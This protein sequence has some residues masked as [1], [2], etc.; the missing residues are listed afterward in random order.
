MRVWVIGRVAAGISLTVVVLLA[1]CSYGTTQPATNVTAT[2]AT[3]HGFVSSDNADGSTYWFEYGKTDLLGN[4]TPDRTTTAGDEPPYPAQEAISGLDPN[5]VYHFRL[6]ARDNEGQDT[7]ACK[8]PRQFRTKPPASTLS[9][10]T[11]HDLYPDYDRQITDYTVRCDEDPTSFAVTAPDGTEVSIDGDPARGGTFTKSVDLSTGQRADFSVTTGSITTTHHVRCLPLDFPAWD[12][13]LTGQ[14]TQEWTLTSVV[15]G[16]SDSRYVIFFNADGVPVWWYKPS[17]GAKPF[18]AKLLSDGNVGFGEWTSGS[19]TADPT[20]KFQVRRLDGS[21]ARTLRTVGTPTDFHEM[22]ELP[23]GHVLLM[24]YPPRDHV[25]LSAF[26]KPSDATVVDGEIQELDANGA[27]VWS[28][29]TKDHIALA[30][31]GR[32]WN[33]NGT[34]A[35]PDGRNAYDIVHMNA[36]EPDGDGLLVSLRHTDAIYRISRADGHV[37][38]KL[39]GTP[40]PQRLSVSHDSYSMTFGGQHD[41]RRLADG[42]VSVHDNGTQLNRPPR[43]V[44]FKINPAKKSA[45]RVETQADSDI[46]NSVCCG[47]ARKLDSN[48]WLVTWGGNGVI[49][50]YAAD[51]SRIF[52]LRFTLPGSTLYRSVAVPTGR[53]S[54]AALRLGMDAMFPR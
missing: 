34:T 32:W 28:W 8:N 54:A 15:V 37:E 20:R 21:L 6:C 39:G 45:I 14:P 22:Q 52:K 38:W 36:I 40:T 5:T 33:I 24:S 25:D 46:T 26:G 44:R 49:G 43:A 9:V 29:N 7:A 35:L 11:T 2:G 1:G 13:D 19:F 12:Y 41:A 18:D 30:E 10:T 17:D 27:L 31:T 42:T 53:I 51:N 48:G 4:K 47:S 16:F 3:L 50:D 23:G